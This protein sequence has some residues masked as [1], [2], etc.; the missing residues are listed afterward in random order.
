MDRDAFWRV[1][2]ACAEACGNPDDFEDLL[3]EQLEEF[4]DDE[5]LGFDREFRLLSAEAYDWGLWGAAYVIG[6]GC[7]DDSFADFR[8]WLISQGQDAFDSALADPDSL[9]DL[10][11]EQEGIEDL[12]FEF[13]SIAYLATEIWGERHPGE[14][15]P[16]TDVEHPADAKGEPFEED[17]SA[18]L[19]NRYPQLWAS[20]GGDEI[21]DFELDED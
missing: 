4:E 14:E 10:A 16:E 8:T 13:E 9:A 15:L 17:D 19:R 5:L 3:R 20:F 6:G 21:D 7:S 12:V 18:T 1:I 2:D 11:A